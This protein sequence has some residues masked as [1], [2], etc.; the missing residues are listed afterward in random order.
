ME[1]CIQ[2]LKVAG[3]PSNLKTAITANPSEDY[4]YKVE[5][6]SERV[7]KIEAMQT[8][9][10]LGNSGVTE[11]TGSEKN[12]VVIKLF[13]D[14]RGHEKSVTIRNLIVISPIH[15]FHI[16]GIDSLLVGRDARY[17]L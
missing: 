1:T 14:T 6:L 10:S 17:L 15:S 2:V 11:L 7:F 12:I 8:T 4:F 9:D 5:K 16:T 13:D 3:G